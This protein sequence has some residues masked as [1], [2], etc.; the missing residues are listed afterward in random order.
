MIFGILGI[1]LIQEP[2]RGRFETSHN[3]TTNT[4]THVKPKL[5]CKNLFLSYI[6]AF[7]EI[8]TN[9]CSRWII[10]AGCLRFWWGY[11]IAYYAAKYFEIYPQYNV[12][13]F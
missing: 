6:D 2:K 4:Q 3:I 7:K 8:F 9:K 5:T 11:T 10:I 12:N 13:Q 1:I